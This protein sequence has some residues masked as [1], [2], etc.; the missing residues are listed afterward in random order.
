MWPFW[1][2]DLE[3]GRNLKMLMHIFIL[4]VNTNILTYRS[5]KSENVDLWPIFCPTGGTLMIFQQGSD[6]LFTWRSTD[7]IDTY[8]KLKVLPRPI[9]PCIWFEKFWVFSR[10]NRRSKVKQGPNFNV[11]L[12][13]TSILIFRKQPC[14]KTLCGDR[15]WSHISF[16][17]FI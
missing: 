14:C 15:Y 1:P 3:K 6:I 17:F 11:D 2:F 7:F 16:F 8:I 10:L 5:T 9:T 4:L 12:F 13:Q